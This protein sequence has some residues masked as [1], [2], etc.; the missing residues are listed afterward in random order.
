MS[1]SHADS[2]GQPWEGRHFEPNASAQ[3]DGSAPPEFLAAVADLRQG[4][5][6]LRDVVDVVR[7]CR[8]LIPLVAV[9]GETAQTESGQTFEKSQELSIITVSGPDGRAI[10]PVFSSV[11]AMAHWRADARPVPADAV[12]VAL[13]A[14]SESTDRIVIDARGETELVLPRPAVWA[15]AQQVPWVPAVEDDAVLEA[16]A[17]SA[18]AHPE[19]WAASL[20]AG[21][22][23]GRGA[24]PEV[25]VRLAIEPGL[26][27]ERLRDIVG[28]LSAAWAADATVALSLD[29]LSVQ[30]IAAPR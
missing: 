7:E 8:F 25:I 26:A 30:P 19:V 21:D 1:S 5:A 6:S 28:A 24:D 16:I 12:R 4:R 27:A 15:I 17:R 20:I 29:S 14:A 3:D 22:P 18:E 13:A 23:L 11:A 2:A 9:A 10:L